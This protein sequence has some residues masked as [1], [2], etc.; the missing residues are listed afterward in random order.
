MCP[1][2]HQV[3]VE[4]AARLAGLHDFVLSLPDCYET[5]C[6][7]NGVQLSKTQIWRIAVARSIVRNP[8]ILLVDDI[9][10]ADFDDQVS[11]SP[12][13]FSLLNSLC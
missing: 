10:P 2:Y 12:G 5:E 9:P 11:L 8:S 4:S 13:L 7:E 1:C 6:G 3:A